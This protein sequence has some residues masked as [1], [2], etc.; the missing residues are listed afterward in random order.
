MSH[1]RSTVPVD[2][3]GPPEAPEAVCHVCRVG[4]FTD[5]VVAVSCCGREVDHVNQV[6]V[7]PAEFAV[8]QF[9]VQDLAE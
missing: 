8:A 4:A 2:V 1:E 3:G 6:I 5:D 9:L 7:F